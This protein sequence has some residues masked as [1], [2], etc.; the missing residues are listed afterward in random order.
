ML[1]RNRNCM[2]MSQNFKLMQ[3]QYMQ[4]TGLTGDNISVLMPL[5][6]MFNLNPDMMYK[7]ACEAYKVFY[8]N[9]FCKETDFQNAY[10]QMATYGV[11]MS[12]LV[13]GYNM[14]TGKMSLY[15]SSYEIL[16]QLASRGVLLGKRKPIA[17][18]MQ[19]I[20]EVLTSGKKFVP[21]LKL[22]TTIVAV[23][24][25][26]EYRDNGNKLV[27]KPTVPRSALVLR[28]E[29]LIPYTALDAAM[30]YLNEVLQEKVLR[31]TCGDK[32]RV[33]TKN[34]AILS[35]IYGEVRTNMLLSYTFDA[36]SN[37]FYVPSVGASIF[38][39]GVTNI[40]L[41]EVDKI[42]QVS[43]LAEIDLSDVKLDVTSAPSYCA[44]RLKNLTN[45]QLFD[46]GK[47]LGIEGINTDR[48]ANELLIGA[49]LQLCHPYKVYEAMKECGGFNISDFKN[50]KPKWGAI[51][52]AQQMEIPSTAKELSDLLKTGIFQIIIHT[53]TGK[54][55]PVVVTNCYKELARLYGND[56]YARFESDGNK[57]RKAAYEC[58][59][60]FKEIPFNVDV[61]YKI[62]S[63]W[64]ILEY[65]QQNVQRLQSMGKEINY[66]NIRNMFR[67]NID[68][69]DERKTVVKQPNIITVRSCN[70]KED[71]SEKWGYY[72]NID[73]RAI[74][75][76]VRLTSV[77]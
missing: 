35:M 29:Y 18:E 15:T 54:Y 12:N 44:V 6:Q 77:N 55:V 14:R 36:R 52:N 27:F 19:A 1:Y 23:R 76:I 7:F 30:K 47:K 16:V 8:S 73:I 51:E 9:G 68:S 60:K 49:S 11:F 41:T 58:D 28:D 3:T 59:N 46:F 34:A 26:W 62:A 5:S 72:K 53:K 64:G 24:L 32:V 74:K 50:Q 43:S 25:D 65:A 56:F 31:I 10:E 39:S 17:E 13:F 40:D 66:Q 42:Q 75:S 4:Q 2:L 57:L 21:S 67:L 61:Y 63:K 71:A 37:S 45:T 70:C 48:N 20:Q 38:S 69:V 22:G 33:V